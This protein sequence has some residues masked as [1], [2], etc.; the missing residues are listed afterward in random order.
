MT[1]FAK[2]DLKYGSDQTLNLASKSSWDICVPGVGWL[3]VMSSSKM[4]LTVYCK[5]KVILRKSI[6][7][8]GKVSPLEEITKKYK[9]KSS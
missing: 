9:Y 1:D 3:T 7:P 2:D 5:A 8:M 6:L 4:K